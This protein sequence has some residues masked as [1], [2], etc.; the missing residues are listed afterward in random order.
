[1]IV[2]ILTGTLF[3]HIVM[4]VVLSSVLLPSSDLGVLLSTVYATSD[5]DLISQDGSTT[6]PP[7]GTTPTTTDCT[8]EQHY[9]KIAGEC[10]DNKYP[11]LDGSCVA[12]YH[13]ETNDV[14][15]TLCG[16]GSIRMLASAETVATS[17]SV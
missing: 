4:F 13:F 2:S 11:L 8:E 14:G 5:D 9:D 6:T 10:V 17:Q 16:A 12:G 1:M 7:D 15:R 3:L